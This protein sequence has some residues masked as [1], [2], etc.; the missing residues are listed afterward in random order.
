MISYRARW[1]FTGSAEFI[2]NGIVTVDDETIVD[3]TYSGHADVELGDFLLLP[4]LINAHTHLEFSALTHAL[5][6]RDQFANWIKSVIHWRRSNTQ[7]AVDGIPLG[8]NESLNSGVA[9]LGEIATSDWRSMLTSNS[10][11]SMPQVVIFRE[12]LGLSE[13]HVARQLDDAQAFLKSRSL[14]KL[15]QPALNPHAPYS[16]HP[17]L[18]EALCQLAEE[19]CVPVAMHLAE[20]PA[21]LELLS[22]GTGSLV[23]FFKSLGVWKENLIPL[24]TR[25]LDYLK[26]LARLPRVLIIHGN[27]LD[28]EEIAFIA[29]Y[30]QMSVIYCPRTHAA[31]QSH[32]H[33]WLAM[34]AAGI[35]IALGTDSRASNPDLSIWKELQF[36]H[37]TF[38]EIAGTQLLSLATSHAAQALGLDHVGKLEAGKQADLCIVR[39]DYCSASSDPDAMFLSEGACVTSLMQ[40]GAWV[41]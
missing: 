18:F 13:E 35:N 32:P 17:A 12:Y 23:D 11:K 25:P 7:I 26:R 19:Q 29:R 40:R 37:Q 15:V 2:E 20:S 22:T 27:Y 16:V 24:K 31:M 38:P 4:A 9:S 28:E 3:V 21:E 6:P 34:Q 8:L 14:C 39:P 41:R 36:L 1:L 33:P 30:P 10:L 5:E